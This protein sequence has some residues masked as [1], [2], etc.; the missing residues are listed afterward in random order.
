MGAVVRAGGG[1]ATNVQ[2]NAGALSPTPPRGETVPAKIRVPR[3]TGLS[4][5]RLLRLLD[6]LW[7][8]RLGLVVAPAGSGKTTLLA[9]FAESTDVPVAW[10]RAESTDVEPAVLLGHLEAA[11]RS[12]VGE[13]PGPWQTVEDAAHALEGMGGRRAVLAIDDLHATRGTPAEEALERLLD[14]LPDGVVVL[15][16]TRALPRFNLPRLRVSGN[17]LELTADDLRFRSW[18]VE[19]LFS[20]IY[21]APLRPEDLAE[22]ARRTEGW[23]AGLQLFHLS[24]RGKGSEDRR[25]AVAALST[26]SRLVREYLARNVLEGLDDDIRDFLLRTSALGRL[27]GALCDELLG[28][29]GSDAVLAELEQGQIFTIALDEDGWY[30]YHE[31]LRSHAE[32]V[33][34]EAVGEAGARAHHRRAGALL[35][36]VGAF[37]EALQAYCRADDWDAAAHLLDLGGEQLVAGPGAWV[38]QLPEAMLQHDPWIMLASARRHRATGRTAA[39]MESYRRAE[40]VF[41]SLNGATVCRQERNAMAAWLEPGVV[42]PPDWSGLLRVATARDPLQVA[43]QAESLP[44]A[45]GPLVAGI[46]RLLA[47]R[48]RDARS[49]LEVAADDAGASPAIV[50]GARL[51][52]GF[53]ALLA[54]DADATLLLDRGT[55]DA[56]QAGLPWLAALG[57]L[58]SGPAGAM[59]GDDAEGWGQ[60]LARLLAGWR[61]LVAGADPAGE[62]RA[63]RAAFAAV[64]ASVLDTWAGSLLALVEV[65]AGSPSGASTARAAIR[66]ARAA[67]VPGAR[68]LALA[69]LAEAQPGV[70]AIAEQAAGLARECDV[71]IPE[72]VPATPG[73]GPPASSGHRNG[74]GSGRHEPVRAPDTE[75]APPATGPAPLEVTCF[76]RFSISVDGSPID[77]ATLK[78]RVRSLL[79]FLATQAGRAAHREA[80]IDALWPEADLDAGTRNLQVAISSLRQALEPGIARGESSLV[81][82]EGDA[83]LLALPEGARVDVVAFHGAVEAGQAARHNGQDEAALASFRRALDLHVGELLPE[84]GPAEWL[85]EARRAAQ[86]ALV[87]AAFA[88][89]EIHAVRGELVAAAFACERGLRADRYR[90]S[91]WQL[92]ID[93]HERSGEQ[94]AAMR[95]RAQYRAVLDDLG[96]GR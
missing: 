26:R 84:E 82:R 48:L 20:E 8:H 88:V 30:R 35:E 54:G 68:A 63:A 55:E 90:D 47:G 76:G 15:A 33:F 43:I 94:A 58:G 81:V 41:G 29:S 31:V 6:T 53:C 89:A 16:A 52:I 72:P 83:Y 50:A 86:S 77:L 36:G 5:D 66:A 23:A 14:Y 67:G 39:A 10:Y 3:A 95:A 27:N 17:L 46:A 64:G 28:R 79:R 19:R 12:V 21:A 85:V 74:S 93:L 38:E 34:V 60:A 92:L 18:E 69:A 49:V 96:L 32:A 71:A 22:L 13:L 65:R 75:P 37:V 44:G 62:L 78:P 2:P 70:G 11:L 9:Q 1:P 24:V 51:A 4:R 42:P 25:Q 45:Y 59:P 91:L 73:A 7:E 56:E 57:R 40:F 61:A 87:E 80:L